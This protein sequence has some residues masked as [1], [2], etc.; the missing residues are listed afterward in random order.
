MDHVI[1]F[2]D[3]GKDIILFVLALMLLFGSNRTYLSSL[4]TVRG[5]DREDIIFEQ[6]NSDD[7]DTITKGELIAMLFNRPE[8]EIEIDGALIGRNEETKEHLSS[9][10]INHEKYSEI[11]QYDS[12]YN[13]T[14]IIFTGL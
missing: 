12:N 6:Y 7:D 13:I 10:G 14:R 4:D 5:T 1:D 3:Q 11:Y 8:Y 9:Y 2:L